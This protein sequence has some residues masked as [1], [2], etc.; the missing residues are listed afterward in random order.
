MS[1][2]TTI[3]SYIPLIMVVVVLSTITYMTWDYNMIILAAQWEM[4]KV[5]LKWFIFPLIVIISLIWLCERVGCNKES[6]DAR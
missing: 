3:G 2:I 1:K 6:K 5:F 4:F